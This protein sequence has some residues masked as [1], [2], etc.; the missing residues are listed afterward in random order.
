MSATTT[1]APSAAS[2]RAVAAPMPDAPPVTSA[3]R[4]SSRMPQT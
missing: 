4:C 1:R 2:R 3:I